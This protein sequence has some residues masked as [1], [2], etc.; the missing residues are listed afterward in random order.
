[1]SDKAGLKNGA[2][3]G[4]SIAAHTS[5]AG[6]KM[7]KTDTES[8][9]DEPAE[10]PRRAADSSAYRERVFKIVRNIPQGRVMTYG[11]IAELL[12][13]GYDARTVGYCMHAADDTVPWHRVINAQG[14]C[15]TGRV[16]LPSN[17]Q[18]LLLEAEGIAFNAAGRCELSRYRWMPEATD[19]LAASKTD[20]EQPSLFGA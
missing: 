15:S 4:W 18:Q 9:D 6:A 14:A 2:H 20:L 13:A 3:G 17:K 7:T 12:G 5:G 16:I 10:A 19:E 11:Q 1:M 8:H